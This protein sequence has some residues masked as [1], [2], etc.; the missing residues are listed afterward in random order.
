[1]RNKERFALVVLVFSMIMLTACDEAKQN[2]PTPTLPPTETAEPLPTPRNTPVLPKGGSRLQT[3]DDGLDL[4]FS[5][6]G[7]KGIAH[8]GALM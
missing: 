2:Q 4:V 5:G 1:M 3:S 6:G 7:A 8:I